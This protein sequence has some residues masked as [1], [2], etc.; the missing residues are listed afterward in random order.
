MAVL[1]DTPYPEFNFRVEIDGVEDAGFSEVGGIGFSTEVIEYRNG[2]DK[3]NGVRK[4]A[5]LTRYA[6]ITLRR[7]VIGSRT[8][9]E[10]LR[11]IADGAANATR[12]VAIV[13]LAEDRTEV[14]R[15]RLHRARIVKH[16][17]GPLNARGHGVAVEEI[18]LAY[19]R[20]EI[21]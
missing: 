2:S 18:V 12:D 3:E 16:V 4:L 15:W 20:L 9:Y 1:R 19:E 21:E 7:G 6:D 10:W 8:F 13:L 11:Q 17:S 14:M 5:G